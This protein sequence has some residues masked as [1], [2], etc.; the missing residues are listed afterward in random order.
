MQSLSNPSL[1][2]TVQFLNFHFMLHKQLNVICKA[3]SLLTVLS[4]QR[5]NLHNS[6]LLCSSIQ[7][8]SHLALIWT[9]HLIILI[10]YKITLNHDNEC[11]VNLFVFT[12]AH[13]HIW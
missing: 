4:N 2:L 7:K 10:F 9:F 5:L 12:F 6:N 3:G 8:Q 11:M 1:E 13:T